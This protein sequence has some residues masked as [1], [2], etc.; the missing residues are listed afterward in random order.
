MKYQQQA[1]DDRYSDFMSLTIDGGLDYRGSVEITVNEYESAIT[2]EQAAS[3]VNHLV[4]V[5]DL[6][7]VEVVVY[8]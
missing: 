1:Y 6:K 4:K 8:E 7:P 3:L 2:K 5:F